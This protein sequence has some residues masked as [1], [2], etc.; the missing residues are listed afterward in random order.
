M[1][2]FMTEKAL[3]ERDW[4]TRVDALLKAHDE[5]MQSHEEDCLKVREQT[6]EELIA[7]GEA[8]KSN[9][10]EWR[11]IVQGQHKDNV[12]RLHWQNGVLITI[13]LSIV[14]FVAEQAWQRI[15]MH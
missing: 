3:E 5:R 8:V 15:F 12:K 13:L 9:H 7:L 2:L 4:R 10:E 1:K 6:N 14:G 11:T